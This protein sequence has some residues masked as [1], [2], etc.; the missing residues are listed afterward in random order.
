MATNNEKLQE[1]SV[2]DKWQH[3]DELQRMDT[4][5]DQIKTLRGELPLVVQDVEDEIAGL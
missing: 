4:E 2:E 1:L 5:I 3:L